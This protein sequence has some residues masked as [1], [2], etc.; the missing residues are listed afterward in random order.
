MI[1]CTDFR[2][3]VCQSCYVDAWSSGM[4]SCFVCRLARGTYARMKMILSVL[5]LSW[6]MRRYLGRM[7]NLSR[8]RQTTRV[9]AT[10]N[11]LQV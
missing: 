7:V 5:V 1:P 6:D 10:A 11:N 2:A 8:R 9:R 4:Q 3:N